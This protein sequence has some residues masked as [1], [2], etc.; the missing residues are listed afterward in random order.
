M[1]HGGVVVRLRIIV[2]I[3]GHDLDPEAWMPEQAAEEIVDTGAAAWQ[4]EVVSAD[5]LEPDS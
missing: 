3:D 1:R 2:D 5:W 4:V